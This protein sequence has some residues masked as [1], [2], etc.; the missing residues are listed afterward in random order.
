MVR[1]GRKG[2]AHRK[3]KDRAGAF[4]QCSLE[5]SFVLALQN[6]DLTLQRPSFQGVPLTLNAET[7]HYIFIHLASFPTMFAERGRTP[8]ID[9]QVYDDSLPESIQDTWSIC[10]SAATGRSVNEALLSR[11][12]DSKT[13]QLIS[14]ARDAHSFSH[15]L[16][17]VQA[18]ILALIMRLISR[19]FVLPPSADA[20]LSTLGKLTFRLWQQA[21][22]QISTS[23]TPRQAWLFAESVRRT[24]LTSHLL[25]GTWSTF[26][27]GYFLHTPFVEALPFDVRTSLWDV[28]ADPKQGPNHANFGTRMVSYREYTDM[29][30]N[31]QIHGATRFG[32]LL[33]VACKGKEAVKAGLPGSFIDVVT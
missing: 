12:L 10:A 29:W 22:A 7:I 16:A 8:F 28:L 23:L 3:A 24:I 33:L 4:A 5:D 2:T 18:L 26:S 20:L 27:H 19:H 30:D 25:R 14:S 13:S 11:S 32:T 9:L 17:S 21:P 6:S 31:G 15:L 1:Q